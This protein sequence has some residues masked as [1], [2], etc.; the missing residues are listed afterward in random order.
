MKCIKLFLLLV[1]LFSYT[2][3]FHFDLGSDV[4]R[5]YLEELYKGSVLIILIHN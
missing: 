3:C 4:K 1:I 2:F 5:C